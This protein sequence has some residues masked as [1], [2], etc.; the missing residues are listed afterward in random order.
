MH[1]E[2][3]GFHLELTNHKVQNKMSP[4]REYLAPKRITKADM[5]KWIRQASLDDNTKEGLIKMLAEYPA[6]TM[7]HFFKNIH[8]HIARLRAIQQEQEKE[9]DEQ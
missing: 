3:F 2:Q 1:F 5:I 7:H 4:G 9:K 8:T 6:N